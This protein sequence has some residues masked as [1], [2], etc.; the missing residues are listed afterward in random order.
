MK[1]S[2]GCVEVVTDSKFSKYYIS[3]VRNLMT[4]GSYRIY[5]VS[6]ASSIRYAHTI[7]WRCKAINIFSSAHSQRVLFAPIP[8][9]KSIQWLSNIQC[10]QCRKLVALFSYFPS[11]IIII[12]QD[13]AF[14]DACE[15]VSEC[16]A[17]FGLCE[18][19]NFCIMSFRMGDNISMS[20]TGI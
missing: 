1:A 2:C 18:S 15:K 11:N 3:F 19:F 6:S 13:R 16:K 4:I 5:S 17:T 7:I 8:R 14:Q 12:I 9:F 20:T 10:K